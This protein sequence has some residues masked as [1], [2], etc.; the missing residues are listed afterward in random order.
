M[1]GYYYEIILFI[2]ACYFFQ[3]RS[4]ITFKTACDSGLL[5]N[6]ALIN[7]STSTKSNV[8]SGLIPTCFSISDNFPVSKKLTAFNLFQ[9]CAYSDMSS[10]I[11]SYAF[12]Y[13][14]HLLRISL[15]LHQHHSPF[16]TKTQ[17]RFAHT[18]IAAS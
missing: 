13:L 15:S 16:Q 8:F 3:S 7:D 14:L 2:I 11:F 17:S 9:L 18:Q 6:L 1:Y 10:Y 12:R 4:F 5:P